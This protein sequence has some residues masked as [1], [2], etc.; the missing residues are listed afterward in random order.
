MT[1]SQVPALSRRIESAL[2]YLARKPETLACL[3]EVL[4]PPSF[5]LGM[6]QKIPGNRPGG[7]R[8]AL[9]LAR[10]LQKRPALGHPLARA[11][12]DLLPS[13]KPPPKTYLKKSSGAWLRREPLLAALRE[14]LASG[15]EPDWKRA[16]GW[17]LAWHP[18]LGKAEDPEPP[19]PLQKAPSPPA[20][21]AAPSD[22][23]VDSLRREKRQ[24]QKDLKAERRKVARLQKEIGK[25]RE[26]RD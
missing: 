14:A 13:T 6:L 1:D 26:E 11:V 18:L 9:Q 19:I 22:G 7:G 21:P 8:P 12:A 16:E 10:R 4:F 20:F 15:V 24:L 23:Q 17:I 5:C 3:L 25:T 2:F